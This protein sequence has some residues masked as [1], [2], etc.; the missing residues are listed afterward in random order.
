MSSTVTGKQKTNQSQKYRSDIDGLRAIAVLSVIL[1]HINPLLLPGG[2]VGVDIFF[3][4]SGYLIS[5]HIYKEIENGQFSLAEFYRRRIKRIAPAMLVVLGITVILA[6]FILLPK[7]AEKVAESG[8]WSLASMANVYFWL[9]QDTSYFAAASNELPL[10]HLWSLG[11]EEQF[12]IFWPLI[13]MLVYKSTNKMRF[14]LSITFIALLSFA[15]GEIYFAKDPSFVYYMLPTRAGELLIGALVAVAINKSVPT[16]LSRFYREWLS[17]T[18]VALLIASFVLLSEEG[19][20]PGYQAIP[21]TLGVALLIF[22]G[23]YGKNWTTLW[24]TLKPMGWVGLISY[25]AYLWHWP[26]LAFYRYGQF[27][28]NLLSGSL[29]LISTLFLAWL[30][31]KYVEQPLRKTQ[32]NA[33]QVFIRQYC[34]PAG[35]LALFAVVAMKLDGYGLRW[36][37]ADYKASLSAAQQHLRYRS[38]YDYVCMKDLVIADDVTDAKC[39]LGQRNGSEPK[40]LLWGDSNAAHFV[41]LLAVFAEDQGYQFRNIEVSACPP[42]LFNLAKHTNPKRLAECMASQKVIQ[43]ILETFDTLFIAAAW[44]TYTGNSEQFISDFEQTIELLSTQVK[45]IIL[46]GKIPHFTQYN[47]HCKPKQVSFPLMNCDVS[48]VPLDQSTIDT[49]DKLVTLAKKYHN[50]HYT[51]FN[52]FLC[53]EGLC[54]VYLGSKLPLYFDKSHMSQSGSQFLGEMI[55]KASGTPEELTAEKILALH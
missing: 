13:L 42:L 55:I 43:P 1:F 32:Y 15:L 20:F 17:A 46:I 2:F 3:V 47:R 8:L 4:I 28:I 49:N 11:V 25:S 19:V 53:P 41:D 6:Q 9:F 39:I 34:I 18:G 24:L 54:S 37:S 30:T 14:A 48:P 38:D 23:H 45:N 10:L 51:D 12:Y 40:A 33:M 52:K 7:D 16:Q 27:D 50:I 21:P 22:I 31:Y 36:F 35:T 44:T 26:I 29:I 5:L